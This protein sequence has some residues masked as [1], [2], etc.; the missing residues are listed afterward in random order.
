ML[1]T[2]AEESARV[3]LREIEERIKLLLAC[4]H[5]DKVAGRVRNSQPQDDLE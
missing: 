3:S 1:A 5:G 2:A 4:D